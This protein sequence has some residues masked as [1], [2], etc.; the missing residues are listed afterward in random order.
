[1][2]PALFTATATSPSSASSR[3]SSRSSTRR[4][5]ARNL[6][7]SLT[8]SP[9]TCASH[10]IG[11]T[12]IFLLGGLSRDEEPL[13]LFLRSGDVLL[14]GGQS[15]LC[16]HGV[17]RILDNSCPPELLLSFATP[18]A[19]GVTPV[20]ASDPHVME[21]LRRIRININIRQVLPDSTSYVYTNVC[22]WHSVDARRWLTGARSSV[23]GL[24][25]SLSLSLFAVSRCFWSD[26]E[27]V[28]LVERLTATAAGADPIVSAHQES[29]TP[30]ADATAEPAC[31]PAVQHA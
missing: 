27:R 21:Y 3:P 8:H 22:S 5:L 6:P 7:L 20:A 24:G 23:M 10:S 9:R 28:A 31:A 12:A 17:P 1:M 14:M 30:T 18:P 29:T 2:Q 16:Y 26:E 13:P 25:D 4:P 11:C 15:R 19:D